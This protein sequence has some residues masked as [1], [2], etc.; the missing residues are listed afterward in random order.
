MLPDKQIML[1]ICF[2]EQEWLN[3]QLN[4]QSMAS[5]VTHKHLCADKTVTELTPSRN[6][7]LKI[8]ESFVEPQMGWYEEKH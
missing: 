6:H 4:I 2:E 5:A 8:D 1:R 7:V 3:A